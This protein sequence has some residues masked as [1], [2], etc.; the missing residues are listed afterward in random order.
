MS[1]TTK[2][3]PMLKSELALLYG[4]SVFTFRRWIKKYED[5][6]EKL[7]YK[8]TDRILTIP[9]IELLFD[10]LGDPT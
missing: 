9:V 8:K 2:V 5:D 6:L 7:G 4:V 3:K 1:D 10:K